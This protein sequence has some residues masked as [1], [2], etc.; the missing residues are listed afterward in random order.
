MFVPW[1]ITAALPSRVPWG[2]S[3][4]ALPSPDP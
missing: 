1:M 4:E 3:P 2:L